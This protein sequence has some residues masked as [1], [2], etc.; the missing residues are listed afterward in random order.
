MHIE[1]WRYYK[2]AALPNVPPHIEVDTKPIE[3]GSIW[4]LEKGVYL[5]RWI[6]EYDCSEPTSWWYVIKDTP[7]DI[8][9]LKAKR[10]YEINK[11]KK[12]FYVK[13]IDPAE[14]KEGIY[15]TQVDAFAVYPEK[16]RPSVNKEKLF[17]GLEKMQCYKFYGAFSTETDEFMGY[18]WL[19]RKGDYIYYAVQKVKP[20]AEKGG[21]NAAIVAHVLETHN[22]ELAKDCYICDGSRN[23]VHDTNFQAYLEKYF[24]FRKAYCKLNIKYKPGFGLVVKLLYPFRGLL[25]K[26]DNKSAIHNINGV[27]KMESFVREG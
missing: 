6:T 11:G 17:E 26:L 5:A 10:R 19:N 25:M 15:Q 3:D 20:A 4:K 1:G 21:I 16:Y 13:E 23:V 24:G 7:F 18:A 14:Y 22:E 8:S 2:H 27:L 9:A 12:N